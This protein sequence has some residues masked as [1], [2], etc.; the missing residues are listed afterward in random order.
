MKR[1]I[2]N[3]KQLGQVVQ[4]KGENALNVWSGDKCN[5]L[6]GSDSTIFPPFLTPQDPVAAF[7]PEICR[8][9][10][11]KRFLLS[12]VS[13]VSKVSNILTTL[14]SF[15]HVTIDKLISTQIKTHFMV[16]QKMSSILLTPD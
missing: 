14:S 5:K 1:G 6:S 11:V 2:K 16:N 7:T 8:C 10:P 15:L 4:F 9:V 3:I 13:A 12:S